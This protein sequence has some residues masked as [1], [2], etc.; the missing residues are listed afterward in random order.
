MKKLTFFLL[1][2][3]LNFHFLPAVQALD[4]RIIDTVAIT[5][6]GA[7]APKVTLDNVKQ[8][9]T[10]EVNPR[11]RSLTTMSDGK[12]EKTINFEF[13]TS[14]ATPI[15]LNSA[16]NCDRG[17]FSTLV[18]SIRQ[19][20]YS[21][22]GITNFRERYLTILT[23]DA[24]CIW[25]GKALIGEKSSKGGILVL[26]N[27]AEAFVIAHELGHT[28]GL[29]HS[30]LMRCEGTS[31][32]GAWGTSC[33]AVEYGGAIDLMSNVNVKAPLSTYH[34]WRMGLM[35]NA[36]VKQSWLSESINLS[37]VDQASGTKAIFLKDGK[38]SYWIEYRKGSP[39]VDYQSGL[40]I[41]RTDPPP[42]SSVV[43]PN[44]DDRTASEF[45]TGVG[46]DMWMLNL[47]NFSYASSKAIG[48]M[49]LASGKSISFFSGNLSI[50]VAAGNNLDEVKVSITRKVDV[51]PPPQPI[52]TTA[53]TWRFQDSQILENEYDDGESSIDYFEIDIAGKISRLNGSPD[54]YWF[55]TY[56]NPLIE[57]RTIYLKDLPEGSYDFK[58]RAV[59]VWGNKSSW[60]DSRSTV[61]D[62]GHPIV[63]DKVRVAA[64]AK[65]SLTIEFSGIR[66]EGTGL[67]QTRLVNPEGWVKQRSI[68]KNNPRLSFPNNSSDSA[69]LEAIDCLGNGVRSSF[70]IA[71]KYESPAS[72]RRTGKWN[73]A[74]S[75]FGPN[76]IK[77]VGSCTASVSL[78]GKYA[79]LT[80][81]SALEV[82][83]SSK[84]VAKV[85][86]TTSNEIRAAATIDLGARKKVIRVSGKDFI[87]AGFVKLD[88]SLTE[89]SV[90]DA[91]ASATDPTLVDPI[92]KQMSRFGFNSDDFVPDWVVLPMARGTTLEDPT[93]DL[94]GGDYKSETGREIR[95]QISVTKV[96]S[97]YVFLSSEVVK[98]KSSTAVLNAI[99]ELKERFAKCQSDGGGLENGVLT[100]Y[101][102]KPWNGN[103]F[104]LVDEK[105]RVLVHA[106][107]G[108][109]SSLRTLLGFYQFKDGYFTG[110]Y[111][112]SPKGEWFSEEEI[113]RWS[114]VARSLA[115][116]MGSLL[117][118]V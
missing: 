26:H 109:G 52:L 11:W 39:E 92:Q 2:L 91:K 74:P 29:G 24:G 38:S 86:A 112:V 64:L 44:P 84:S 9:I 56:L 79:I 8:V 102:F 93:L 118:N 98:Y 88:L 17:D 63:E 48:S 34:Q 10:N 21:K 51:L 115:A 75:S 96:G 70:K 55:P 82:F 67:C 7:G 106:K 23:P 40:V 68:S 14:L 43:S 107:I 20:T 104:G 83:V 71:N 100:P 62:R 114:D 110:L 1:L 66:D 45:G 103:T 59:D 3:T 101:E 108:S 85:S 31:I 60:S 19:E 76:A 73:A 53:S 13:G 54:K 65:D 113:A 18:S 33:R 117:S 61:V 36:S 69:V 12:T 78:A 72:T 32:E 16:L 46:T 4:T 41:Y 47:D 95:R 30:N 111:I 99:Q 116:R 94:C 25:S 15:T 49:T 42:I 58:I 77:C 50:S 35:D 37:A 28:L 5:W 80:G 57:P 105:S 6:R 97:P 22:L 81:S 87:L 89:K 90:F 27:N